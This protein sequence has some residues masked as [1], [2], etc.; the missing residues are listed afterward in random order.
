MTA[1]WVEYALVVATAISGP[2]QVYSTSSDSRAMELPTTLT[3]DRILAPRRL[4]SRRAAMVSRV[5]P[6][7]L[8]VTTRVFSSTMGDMY[9]N[10]E[11]RATS[12]GL[13]VSRSM[14]YLPTM[15]T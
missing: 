13:R 15:P 3:M 6:D 1:I 12:T 8:M 2:A 9:R 5:S 4:A 10:S 11:A 14:L 7:W